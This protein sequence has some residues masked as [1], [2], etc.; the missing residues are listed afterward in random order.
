MKK[1]IVPLIC[2]VCAL[3][4]L[5]TSFA[6]HKGDMYSSIG[7]TYNK[8]W[9]IPAKSVHF[10]VTFKSSYTGSLTL[11]DENGKPLSGNKY[12]IFVDGKKSGSSFYVSNA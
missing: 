8:F 11:I 5:A 4:L 7:S 1:W 12:T 10:N 3:F 6:G 2:V 9:F